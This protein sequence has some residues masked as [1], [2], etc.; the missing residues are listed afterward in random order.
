MGFIPR[1]IPYDLIRGNRGAGKEKKN[2][3]HSVFC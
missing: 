3:I 2:A 1:L